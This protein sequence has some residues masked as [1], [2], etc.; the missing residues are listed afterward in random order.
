[1]DRRIPDDAMAQPLRNPDPE[2]RSYA[3]RIRELVEQER[4]P[5]ARKLLAEALE[6][7][8]VDEDLAG[9][10]R[11]L[12]PA[13]SRISNKE[14]DFDRTP[15]ILWIQQHGDRYHRQWVALLGSEWLAHSESLEA[16]VSEL[17]KNR[18]ARR[19][20]LHYID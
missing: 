12:A 18:P 20:L 6:H 8:E 4:V 11:V 2:T 5:A 17:Q 9:W 1:M 7:G 15:E 14:R 16:V 10:Q 19:P 3:E 13:Q